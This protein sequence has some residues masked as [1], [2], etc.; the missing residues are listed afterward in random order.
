MG[1]D[2]GKVDEVPDKAPVKVPACAVHDAR[3]VSDEPC[4]FMFAGEACDA[5]VQ[6]L[7]LVDGMMVIEMG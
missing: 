5:G 6:V 7:V 1:P 4:G 2:R 3:A